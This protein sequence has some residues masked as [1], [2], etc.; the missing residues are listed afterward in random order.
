M[1]CGERPDTV[2]L[3]RIGLIAGDPKGRTEDPLAMA[4]HQRAVSIFIPVQNLSDD[5]LIVGFHSADST[6]KPASG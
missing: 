1:A 6:S 2:Y 5:R 3:V 4:G